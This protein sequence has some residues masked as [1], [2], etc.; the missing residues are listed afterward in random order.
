MDK[1]IRDQDLG[2]KY[3]YSNGPL[4]SA[5][6]RV[7]VKCAHS[8]NHRYNQDL[9]FPPPLRDPLSLLLSCNFL[10]PEGPMSCPLPILQHSHQILFP[11]QHP[12]PSSARVPAPSSPFSKSREGLLSRQ[13]IFTLANT[14]SCPRCVPLGE[15]INLS[16]PAG[17][18]SIRWVTLEPF[19]YPPHATCEFSP[20]RTSQTSVLWGISRATTLELHS[21]SAHLPAA[22]LGPT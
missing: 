7:L 2:A 1:G 22:T 16:Q 13:S 11:S 10:R 4:L 15:L 14:G 20:Q 12:V 18:P 19:P 3:A 5:M 8:C 6:C 17:C 9:E 21:W